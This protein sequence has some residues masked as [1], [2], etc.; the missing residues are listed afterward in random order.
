MNATSL[1]H[2]VLVPRSGLANRI[3]A[4]AAAK[5]LCQR[6]G[7]R[8][9]IVW[10][11]QNYEALFESDPAIE[12]LSQIP[13]NLAS[14]YKVMQT[15][16]TG[17]EH[18]CVPLDGPKGI[19]L[20]SQHCFGAVG[21]SKPL[22]EFDLLPWLPQ[23]SLGVREKARLFR[24]Q[25]FPAGAI[26]GFHMRRTDHKAAAILSPDWLFIRSAEECVGRGAA[27]YLATDN[28][29]TE[30]MMRAR[31]GNRIVALPK[32]PALAQR[33]P[34]P[35]NLDE[36]IAD[37]ADLL[38]LASCDYV[39]GSAD[40]SYSMLAMALNGSPNCRIAR[41]L[42]AQSMSALDKVRGMQHRFRV[43]LFRLRQLARENPGLKFG[44]AI[45]RA[46]SARRASRT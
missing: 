14:T 10:D 12:V 46:L 32:N 15:S 7:A 23:P 16:M 1:E 2:L 39:L 13:P 25:S 44:P 18:R 31:F 37:Y 24:G 38:L 11:W 43:L 20:T 19:V 33:W 9:T 8:C 42:D 17:T 36:T 28:R 45:L 4:I 26:V 34:R 3:R 30:E 5:R 40:S 6:S 21:E 35:F 41:G 29:D 27:I 22:D